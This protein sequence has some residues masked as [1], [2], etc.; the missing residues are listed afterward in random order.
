MATENPRCRLPTSLGRSWGGS[1]APG[2]SKTNESL[3][4]NNYFHF[5]VLS[6]PNALSE[7]QKAS[8]D[9]P[10]APRDAPQGVSGGPKSLSE[11]LWKHQRASLRRPRSTQRRLQ[12]LQ[13]LPKASQDAPEAPKSLPKTSPKHPKT[14]PR[15]P[16][17]SEEPPCNVPETPQRQ[18]QR[19]VCAHAQTKQQTIPSSKPLGNEATKKL[20][21][22]RRQDHKAKHASKPLWNEATQLMY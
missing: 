20:E 8:R 16:R 17:S 18:L 12:R 6:A 4:E 15:E 2:T 19:E 10:K 5:C 21:T 11:M 13:E 3:K 9:V 22:T 7:P 14:L 1:G